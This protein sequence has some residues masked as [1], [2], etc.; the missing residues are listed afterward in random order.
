MM[1]KFIVA[2]IASVTAF[3]AQAEVTG[4]MTLTSDY[5]FRGISQ[6]EKSLAVQGGI[7]F[8]HDVGVYLGT[9]NSSRGGSYYSDQDNR[10]AGVE[11]NIYLGFNKNLGAFS[12]DVGAIKYSYPREKDINSTEIY[13]GLGYDI[14]SFKVN[15]S[16]TDYFGLPESKG[17]KYYDLTF[18]IPLGKTGVNL[19]A[20]AG[21]LDVANTKLLDYK[22]YRVGFYTDIKGWTLSLDYYRVD[23]KSNLKTAL[24]AIGE[25]DW[26]SGGAVSVTKRF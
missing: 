13:L 16:T 20:H 4:S 2:M 12:F 8:Q 18:D 10:T 7:D 6:S 26:K 5:R 3:A 11:N 21:Y 24:L 17:S 9:W 25:N 1:K 19:L 14:I 23:L 15:H 22:D